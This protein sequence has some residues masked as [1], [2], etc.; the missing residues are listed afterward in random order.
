MKLGLEGG[1]ETGWNS[2]TIAIPGTLI[3][4]IMGITGHHRVSMDANR[5]N[6]LDLAPMELDANPAPR[7]LGVN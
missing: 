5:L 4:A 7:D 6:G 2:W 1:P 3:A